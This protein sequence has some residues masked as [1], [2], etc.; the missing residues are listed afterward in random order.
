MP[1]LEFERSNVKRLGDGL[2]Q[3]DVRMRNTRVM[4]TISAQAIARKLHR[5]DA[6]RVAGKGV[7][8]VAAGELTD[9][10]RGRTRALQVFG[11]HVFVEQGIPG[12]ATRDVRLLVQAAG[13]VTLVYDSQKGGTYE[14]TLP[15]P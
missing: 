13:P 1:R 3:I 15:L 9:L 11:D 7:R 4:P 10:D 2:V 6:L 8:L 5:A 12:Y 14:K